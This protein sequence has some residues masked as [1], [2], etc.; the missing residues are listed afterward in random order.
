MKPAIRVLYAV[1]FVLFSSVAATAEQITLTCTGT[2]AQWNSK[3]PISGTVSPTTATIDFDRKT[4]SILGGAYDITRVD[5]ERLWLSA[6]TSDLVFQGTVD[7]NTGIIGIW[8][9][10]R[11][12]D[13]K[14]RKGKPFQMSMKIDLTCALAKRMF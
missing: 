11:E 13:A 9:V 1:A 10:S 7:R 2:M 5:P 12:E 4:A 6:S 3:E 14:F 8:A